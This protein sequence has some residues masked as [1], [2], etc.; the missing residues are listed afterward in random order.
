MATEE[1]PMK[2][3]VYEGAC[4]GMQYRS[5]VGIEAMINDP[6]CEYK[7]SIIAEPTNKYNPK[8]VAVYYAQHHIG[9][10]PDDKLDAAH[11]FLAWKKT[12]IPTS[13]VSFITK[14]NLDPVNNHPIW[15]EFGI[16]VEYV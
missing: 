6:K 8:A 2:M 3:A 16:E 9:Y 4:V 11:Q 5:K 10:I 12:V 13:S 7:L 14:A 1:V 15:I